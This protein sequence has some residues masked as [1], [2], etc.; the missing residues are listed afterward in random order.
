MKKLSKDEILSV[1]RAELEQRPEILFAYLFG[2]FVEEEK[3]CDL[4]VAVF[5]QD[6]QLLKD[7]LT[8]RIDLS[9][10]LQKETECAV[11]VVVMNVA[12][13]HLIHS[14]AKGMVLIDRDEQFRSEWIERSLSRYFDDQPTRRRAVA[15]LFT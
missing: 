9:S 6:E 8:Y 2:S 14:I 12:S 5:L 11:D 7:W 15:E 13:N 3:F 1:R 4:D 10:D